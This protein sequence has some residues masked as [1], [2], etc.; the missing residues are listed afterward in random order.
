MLQRLGVTSQGLRIQREEA[1]VSP[2]WDKFR[3][4]KGNN[5]NHLNPLNCSRPGLHHDNFLRPTGL[6]DCASD[7]VSTWKLVNNRHNAS[8]YPAFPVGTSSY[9]NE[10]I[11]E[12]VRIIKEDLQYPQFA[13]NPS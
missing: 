11:V 6:L 12:V 2:T 5:G 9:H 8:I 7:P 4:A 13:V 1:P 3:I 10:V